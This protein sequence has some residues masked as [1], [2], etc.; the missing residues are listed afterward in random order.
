VRTLSKTCLGTG[1]VLLGIDNG[2]VSKSGNHLLCNGSTV[3]TSA[4]RT[5]SQT[6]IST[7]G[8]LLGIDNSIV[9]KSGLKLILTMSTNLTGCAGRSVARSVRVVCSYYLNFSGK[10]YRCD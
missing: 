1:G 8:I 9:S 10:T 4:V 6:C 3:T 5:L 2:I 7:S